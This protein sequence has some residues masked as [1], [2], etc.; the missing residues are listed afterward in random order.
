MNGKIHAAVEVNL[1]IFFTD[2]SFDIQMGSYI[3]F[4][5]IEFGSTKT[6]IT[7]E[8]RGILGI[9][10]IEKISDNETRVVAKRIFTYSDF[11]SF[12]TTIPPN[13][14]FVTISVTMPIPNKDAKYYI[15]IK[16]ED[17]YSYDDT[18]SNTIVNDLDFILAIEWIG[19]VKYSR[20]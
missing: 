19:L 20:G 17:P 9:Y 4:L 11:E 15:A 8:S 10:L 7:D 3:R 12:E 13:R 18:G 2:N 6:D 1:R 14:N 16:L 5:F